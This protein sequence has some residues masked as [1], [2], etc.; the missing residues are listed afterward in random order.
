[1]DKAILVFDI[2]GVIRN[3]GGSYRRAIVDT[4]QH[5]TSGAFCPTL[6]D[7]DQLKSEGVWNNDWEASQELIYRYFEGQGQKRE[8]VGLDY[9]K[10]VAF[11]QS[12]YRGPNEDNWTGYICTEPLLVSSDYFQ[13]LTA[14]GFSWGFFSGAMRAEIAYVLEGKLGLS[15]P[16]VVAMEDGPGKPDPT[17]L[18]AVLETLEKQHG[19]TENLPVIYAGDTVGDMYTVENARLAMP[20]RSWV[21]VGVLPP[22]VQESQTRRETYSTKLL[23]AGAKVVLSNVEELSEEAIA[24]ALLKKEEGRRKKEEGKG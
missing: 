21:G 4:V 2:D 17:G 8:D 9:Q 12:R 7:I 18:F 22:H 10:L 11:F 14:A 3:V 6:T 19:L 13:R 23:E 24:R 16:V 15:S 1:M 5:F 20:S